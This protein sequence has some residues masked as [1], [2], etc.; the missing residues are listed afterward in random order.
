MR[1]LCHSLGDVV[2][3]RLEFVESTSFI[4]A[5]QLILGTV[6][7]LELST[8]KS[9]AIAVSFLFFAPGPWS[10]R[11]VGNWARV[12]VAARPINLMDKWLLWTSHHATS[13][14]LW[15]LVTSYPLFNRRILFVHPGAEDR[16]GLPRSPIGPTCSSHMHV[17]VLGCASW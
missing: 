11:F 4:K 15:S 14:A 10:P 8:V 7:L 13:S 9:G 5:R 16:R 1:R 2:S 12:D 6:T 3:P 17:S